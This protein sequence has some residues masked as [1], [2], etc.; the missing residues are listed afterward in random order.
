MAAERRCP[1][2]RHDAPLDAAEM[3]GMRLLERFAVAAEDTCPT[4]SRTD[5]QPAI[6]RPRPIVIQRIKN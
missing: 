2:R 5:E 4:S 3:T 6:A 1:A